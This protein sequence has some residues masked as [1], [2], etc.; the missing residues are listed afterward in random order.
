MRVLF[1]I[2]LGALLLTGATYFRDT[3]YA[4]PSAEPPVRPIVNWDVAGDVTSKALRTIR[5][6]F[7][8]LLG[9]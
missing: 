7:D 9:R 5:T 6:E 2:I 3:T 4:S 8:R 1:G